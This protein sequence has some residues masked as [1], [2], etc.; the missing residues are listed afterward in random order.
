MCGINV[1]RG[2]PPLPTSSTGAKPCFRSIEEALSGEGARKRKPFVR[3]WSET[4]PYYA[5]DFC[6]KNDKGRSTQRQ[7]YV[8]MALLRLSRLRVSADPQVL[9]ST[10]PAGIEHRFFVGRHRNLLIPVKGDLPLVQL[11]LWTFWKFDHYCSPYLLY[12]EVHSSLLGRY[13]TA[14]IHFGRN[15]RHFYSHKHRPGAK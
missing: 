7:L 5:I 6:L 2:F 12:T 13:R 14:W 11:F 9:S 1:V 8:F 10:C 3:E 15:G 4:Y